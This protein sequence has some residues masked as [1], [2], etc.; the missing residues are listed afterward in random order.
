MQIGAF[1][2]QSPDPPL[3]EPHCIAMLR[4][5]VNVGNVGATALR[6]LAEVFGATEIGRLSRPSEFY[7][8]TRYRPQMN[9]SGDRRTVTVPNTIVFAGRRDS[10]P[11]LLLL[12][13]L[14][15]HARAEDFNDS[16]TEV[17]RHLKV[18]RWVLV[19]G[20]YDSVPHSRPLAVT[21]SARGWDAPPELGGV[22]LRRG[23]YQ[24]PTSMTSDLTQRM[25]EQEGLETLS[26]IVHLP[27]YL[28]LDDDYR[29][30][31]RLLHALSPV[32]GLGE[33]LPEDALGEQQYAQVT[34]ALINNP[35]L[36]E[37][38]AR[39]EEEYDRRIAAGNEGQTEGK[40]E[41]PADI[42]RFL[43][44]LENTPENG[45]QGPQFGDV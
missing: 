11:D 33:N 1:D 40:V 21:G 19:G 28:K 37:L 35:S 44:D 34:P 15:P 38:V 6:R 8:Y 39:L 24:G 36:A 12:Q 5:W 17:L 41:L 2:I 14:E 29:G 10:P 27:L 9:L 16:I 30:A 45:E 23:S 13:M 4:P 31:A 43:K 32:Y 26:L 25:H 42:E 3:R 7:D 22:R 20:M 18:S